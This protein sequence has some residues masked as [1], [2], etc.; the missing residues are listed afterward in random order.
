MRSRLK[1]YVKRNFGDWGLGI[2]DFPNKRLR[3]SPLGRPQALL[4]KIENL[5]NILKI[6]D[7]ILDKQR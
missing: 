1:S 3:E 2:G 5:I 6:K 4:A 7:G